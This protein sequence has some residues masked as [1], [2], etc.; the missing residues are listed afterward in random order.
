MKNFRTEVKNENYIFHNNKIYRLTNTPNSLKNKIWT[1]DTI[2]K[3]L[4]TK[5]LY[6]SENN[7][8]TLA[9]KNQLNKNISIKYGVNRRSKC[10]KNY[11]KQ[12][13]SCEQKWFITICI[14]MILV[15]FVDYNIIK[16]K[17]RTMLKEF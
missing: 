8:I 2:K 4:K 1:N 17:T 6:L 12:C 13:P 15:Y 14:W 7:T 16:T 9:D 3:Y 10:Y 5:S 11:A